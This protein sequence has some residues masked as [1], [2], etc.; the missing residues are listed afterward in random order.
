MSRFARELPRATRPSSTRE[1]ASAGVTPGSLRGSRWRQV[2]RGFHVPADTPLGAD[3]PTQRIVE[4]STVAPDAA[5]VTGWAGLFVHGTDHLDGRAG[6]AFDPVDVLDPGAA[7]RLPTSLL[8]C[9]RDG[10][11][12]DDLHPRFGLRVASPVRSLLDA[13]C[14]STDLTRAVIVADAAAHAGCVQLADTAGALAAV[15]GRRGV[16]QA[17]RAFRLADAASRSPLESQIRVIYVVEARL[18]R[19]LVNVPVF[20][21]SG[22]LVAIVDLLDPEAGL[23]TEIDGSHHRERGQHRADNE[24]EEELESLGLVVVR[25]DSLDAGRHRD[26]LV[27]RFQSGYRR[28]LARDRSLDAWTLCEPDWWIDQNPTVPLDDDIK[29]ALFAD[30]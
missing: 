16:E 18:P 23:V 26:R 12:P 29:A 25:A 11:G 28:G 6:A 10:F 5:V 19:P 22:R 8:R 20:D 3:N 27:G 4:A 7:G 15:P 14:W 24:R 30:L 2:S 9:H 17:R 21:R 13:V 1:L